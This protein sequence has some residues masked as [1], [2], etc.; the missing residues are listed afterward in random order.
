MGGGDAAADGYSW[1]TFDGGDILHYGDTVVM[2]ELS[3]SSGYDG[4]LTAQT[5]RVVNMWM[6]TATE[7]YR[8]ADTCREG[9][10]ADAR[11]AGFNPADNAAAF[12]LGTAV[13]EETPGS[14]LYA[15]AKRAEGMFVDQSEGANSRVLALLTELQEGFKE[16]P[17]L[18]PQK[19]EAKGLELKHLAS[20]ITRWMMVPMLQYFIHHLAIQVRT[21][22]TC[23]ALAYFCFP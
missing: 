20:E 11:V 22:L 17:I 12:W 13:D 15:W 1:K 21:P 7:L 4:D 6:A 19:R 2:D 18:A 3:K 8:A 10:D 23:S 5:A 16:C 9:Y 14:S